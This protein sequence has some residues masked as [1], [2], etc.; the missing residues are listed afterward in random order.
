MPNWT[1]PTRCWPLRGGSVRRTRAGRVA[2]CGGQGAQPHGLDAHGP[3]PAGGADRPTRR[4]GLTNP[5]IG[6]QLFLSRHTVEWHLRKVFSN[7]SIS[8][9]REI[10]AIQFDDESTSA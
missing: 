4:E 3:H 6:A 1:S 9:R 8:S 10:S 7:L 2:G 5:E